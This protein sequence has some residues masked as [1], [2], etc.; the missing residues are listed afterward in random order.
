MS[1]TLDL[2]SWVLLLLGSFFCITAGVGMIRMP[3]LFTRSHAASILDTMGA[4]LILAGL[5]FQA[6]D[7]LIA[8]KLLFIFFFLLITNLAAIHALAQ[9]VSLEG[10]HP[11]FANI[12]NRLPRNTQKNQK[13]NQDNNHREPPLSN[14]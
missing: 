10:I 11:K 5:A 3:D 12:I 8:L 14:S 1:L 9:A 2:I 13:H 6:P 7:Y 4:G